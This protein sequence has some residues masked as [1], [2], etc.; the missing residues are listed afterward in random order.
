MDPAK[1]LDL[2]KLR[3]YPLRDRQHLSYVNDIIIHPGDTLL[4][5][6]DNHLQQIC[7]IEKKLRK[8]RDKGASTVLIYGAHLIKNGLAVL[9]NELI[10]AGWLTH[11]AT[12]GAGS[13]HD[14]ELAHLG[15]STENVE[16]GVAKGTFG[17][18]NETAKNI[19]LAILT[20]ALDSLGYGQSLGRF[21]CENGCTLP[22]ESEL[23]EAIIRQPA[24]QLTAARADLLYIMRHLS[25]MPGPL[26]V[27]HPYRKTSILASAW[28]HNVPFTV[29]PSIGYD[30]I[31]N[32]PIFSGSAIGR[33][34]EWD[35]KLFGGSLEDLD[36]GVTL[37]V[38]SAIMGPQ[39]FEKALNCVNNIKI[40]KGGCPVTD[41]SIYVVDIQDGGQWDWKHGEPPKTNPAYYLRFCKSYSRMGGQMEYIQCD[42]TTFIQHLH[43]ILIDQ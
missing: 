25:L 41:H 16:R 26:D 20:G 8:A 21:I 31:A 29:H 34:G 6:S 40:E 30:I 4:P 33:A 19:H 38:G 18:W 22:K 13:I 42:N 32:H 17:A 28:L 36:G 24:N 9:V 5:I 35:F 37:S 3:V 2:S 43:R 12:N 23:V 11:I 39:V 1:R 15:A 10:E 27:V 7:T 14:W